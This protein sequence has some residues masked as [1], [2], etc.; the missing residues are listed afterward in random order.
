MNNKVKSEMEKI[1]IP[2]ELHERS[3]LGIQSAKQ[4]MRRI[5][6]RYRS[7]LVAVA[8]SIALVV[9][10]Y[11]AYLQGSP[12]HNTVQV[13]VIKLP[14]NSEVKNL[15]GYTDLIVYDGKVYTQSTTTIDSGSAKQLLGV[16]LGTTKGTIYKGSIQD[17]YSQELA[18]TISGEDVYTVKG[19]D[20]DFR[21]MTYTK[22]GKNVKTRFFEKLNGITIKD[23]ADIFGKLKL[24]GNIMSSEYRLAKDWNNNVDAYHLIDNNRVVNNFVKELMHATPFL[25]ENIEG[26]IDAAYNNAEFRELSIHL[27]DG[28]WVR[29]IIMQNGYIHYGLERE[30]Y[31]RMDEKFF[32]QMWSELN[33]S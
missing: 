19:Y 16:K 4:E 30:V 31:F 18:S 6:S 25:R 32:N 24:T 28:F 22:S 3:K 12:V 29:L 7:K 33:P 14:N 1:E 5:R 10:G 13:P 17:A 20:E 21:I 23:G 27:K 26:D 8:A 2:G 11:S 15:S 9:G